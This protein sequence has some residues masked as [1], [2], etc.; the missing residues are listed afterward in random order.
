[1]KFDLA[2]IIKRC[3]GL[4]ELTL[5][6]THDEIDKVIREM[7]ADKA[8]GPDGFTGLFL[9]RCWPIIKDDFYN[10]CHQ[11]HNGDLSLE[12][13]NDGFITLIPKTG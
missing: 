10:L 8:P 1:M 3:E 13:I 2:R 12:S 4:D 11:F 6:F 5:P 7:P 9:K